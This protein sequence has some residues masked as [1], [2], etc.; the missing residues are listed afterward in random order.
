MNSNF[1][2]FNSH[3]QFDS[4]FRLGKKIGE[5]MHSEVFQCF[6]HNDILSQNPFAVKITREDD[7]EKKLQIAKE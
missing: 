4:E 3:S 5:G 1:S 2:D 7:E 6:K